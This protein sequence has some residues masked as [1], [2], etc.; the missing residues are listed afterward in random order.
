ME[1][2]GLNVEQSFIIVEQLHQPLLLRL[3]F[4]H[5]HKVNIDFHHRVMTFHDNLVAVTCES[6]FGYASSVKKVVIQAESEVTIP[7]KLSKGAQCATVLLEPAE[8]AKISI[9][10]VLGAWLILKKNS[11]KVN[12]PYKK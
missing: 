9:L 7:I 10:L 6:K 12:E 5:E 8:S 4:M 11:Y 3:D 1:I 2:S